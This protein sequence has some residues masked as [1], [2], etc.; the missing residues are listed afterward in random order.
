MD[1]QQHAQPIMLP[2][3]H[4][5]PNSKPPGPTRCGLLW[6]PPN[7]PATLNAATTVPRSSQ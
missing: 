6:A 4:M 2:A 7:R 5:L 1:L 3:P